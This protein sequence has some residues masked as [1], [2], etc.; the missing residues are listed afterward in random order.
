MISELLLQDGK[1][2]KINQHLTVKHPTIDDIRSSEKNETD[3]NN[4]VS[5]LCLKPY[6]LMVELDD[7]GI[8]YYTLSNYDIFLMLHSIPSYKEALKFLV[9]EYDF[10]SATNTI[11]NEQ[12]LYDGMNDVVID[13]LIY[14]EMSNFI[15]K[16]NF[17][18]DKT[19]FNPGNKYTRKIILEEKRRQQNRKK[20]NQTEFSK[21]A[22]QIR[23]LVWNNQLGVTY[24]TVGD[25]YIYQFYEGIYSLKKT[26][27]YKQIMNGIYSG[28][29]DQK[30]I[31][32]E[33]ID[34]S[35]HIKL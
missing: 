7:K 26:D 5:L 35:A 13:R 21:L 33:D 6:D 10:R 22:S 9:G 18:S 25:L 27:H 14:S 19:E 31:N 3:Y 16:I 8:D 29:V 23:F 15:K 4:A 1:S 12:I 34:W 20:N 32:F 2:Y 17:I 28:N 30:N 11:N 24:K